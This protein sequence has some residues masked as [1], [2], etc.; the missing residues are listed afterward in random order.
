MKAAA[1]ALPYE[2]PKLSINVQVN[3]NDFADRLTRPLQATNKVIDGRATQVLEPPKVDAGLPTDEVLDHSSHSLSCAGS[4]EN[5]P[6]RAAPGPRVR[7]LATRTKP[8]RLHTQVG[9]SIIGNQ[10]MP[11]RNAL[12]ENSA[13]QCV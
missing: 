1:E 8:C 10:C 12:A 5:A 3:G 7:A 2:R 11:K 6:A 4:K 9:Y 13:R